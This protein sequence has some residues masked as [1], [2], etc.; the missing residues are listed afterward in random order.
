MRRP[1]HRLLRPPP[2]PPPPTPPPR[3]LIA[4]CS[5]GTAAWARRPAL[6]NAV[7]SINDLLYYF[8]I[9]INTSGLPRALPSTPGLSRALLGSPGLS[10]APPGSPGL[11]VSVRALPGSAGGIVSV[12]WG[13]RWTPPR[14]QVPSNV[15]KRAHAT[16][17][18]R[19]L[20]PWHPPGPPHGWAVR[21]YVPCLYLPRA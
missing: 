17:L 15:I 1:R 5:S 18:G 12:S 11:S 6:W 4:H 8:Y 19:P 16:R 20:S 2:L 10:R 21:P 9:H 13:G 7:V 14:S 3:A